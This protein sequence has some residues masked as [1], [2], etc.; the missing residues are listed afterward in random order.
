MTT[1]RVYVK[2]TP[3][4]TTGVSERK[5]CV[6]TVWCRIQ[7]IMEDLYPG[8]ALNLVNLASIAIQIQSI[9]LF[10]LLLITINDRN[11]AFSG[12]FLSSRALA[13]PVY[14]RVMAAVCF[15]W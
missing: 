4:S 1:N 14:M 6:V 8:G 12:M 3:S 7:P 15:L 5:V 2:K 10:L 13:S 11:I 9:I